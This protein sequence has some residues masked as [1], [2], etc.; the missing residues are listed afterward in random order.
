MST[1][2]MSSKKNYK[3]DL[4]KGIKISNLFINQYVSTL[5]KYRQIFSDVTVYNLL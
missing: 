4:S 2:T 3:T 5:H 1:A